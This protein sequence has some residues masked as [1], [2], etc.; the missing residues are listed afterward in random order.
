MPVLLS[1]VAV[2]NLVSYLKNDTLLITFIIMK[3]KIL[4]AIPLLIVLGGS[5]VW[6]SSDEIAKA[7]IKTY[8]MLNGEFF[9]SDNE[10]ITWLSTYHGEAQSEQV[11]ISFCQWGMKNQDSFIRLIHQMKNDT[12]KRVGWTLY[13][14]GFSEEFIADHKFNQSTNIKKIIFEL[15]EKMVNK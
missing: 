1:K 9:I 6:I 15:N 7:E 4:F 10:I 8:T 13:D 3:N 2:N 14:V 11:M 12:L 5:F